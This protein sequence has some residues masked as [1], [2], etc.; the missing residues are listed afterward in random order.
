MRSGVARAGGRGVVGRAEARDDLWRVGE[1]EG[2]D[3]V[4]LNGAVDMMILR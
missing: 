3:G 1:T 4:H 2:R